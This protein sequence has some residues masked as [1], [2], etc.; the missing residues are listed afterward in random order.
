MALIIGNGLAS[1]SQVVV[2]QS[3]INQGV[4]VAT[5]AAESVMNA[6]AI[7]RP[8]VLVVSVVISATFAIIYYFRKFLAWCQEWVF[9]YEDEY[10]HDKE[11]FENR[12][13]NYVNARHFQGFVARNRKFLDFETPP[14]TP[15][16]F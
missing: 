4:S 7:F 16:W 1:W 12:M 8:Q 9:R 11:D 6:F 15:R 3:S 13:Q 5:N 2:P 14:W 10:V